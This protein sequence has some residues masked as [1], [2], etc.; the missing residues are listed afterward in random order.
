MKFRMCFL[1]AGFA[2]AAAAVEMPA[3]F[4]DNMVLQCDRAV[5]VWGTARPGENITVEFR[6]Q[7]VS[8]P[9]GEDGKWQV[10]LQPMTAD[11]AGATLTVKG[12]NT[13]TF[14]NV[15]TGDVW[16]CAG[17]SNMQFVLKDIDGGQELADKAENPN[18]RLFKFKR[19]WSRTPRTNVEGQWLMCEPESAR[20]FSAVGY[21]VGRDI[22]AEVKVPVGL[23]SIAWGGCRIE[24]MIDR[25]AWSEAQAPEEIQKAVA[26]AFGELDGR[27]DAKL[28]EDKQ[29]LPSVLFNA[30]VHPFSPFAVRGMLWYQGEDN[31]SEGMR[32]AEKLRVLAYCWRKNFAY[33]NMPIF[34]VQLPPFQYGNE[35][36][37]RIPNFW[38]AQQYFAE[39]DRN[40]GFVVA[41]DSGNPK[42]IHPTNKAPLAAR[43][44]KLVLYREYGI[45]DDSALAPTFR[46]CTRD[47][48][49][50]I[51]E[52]NHPN[53]LKTRD[54]QGVSHLML[55]GGGDEFHPASGVIENDKLIVT[56]PEVPAPARLRFGWDKVANPNLVNRAGVPAA[57]FDTGK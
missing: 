42:D 16:L 6:Q 22:A 33:E 52:F 55:S 15:L 1:I 26:G 14:Q 39:H 53:G 11:A 4:S 49:K 30:M 12:D 50:L 25:A 56:S 36:P 48:N 40:S 9:A 44:A 7:K 19:D 35:N 32:Y 57:P 43:L 51:V 41:T 20:A 47:G 24:S 5:P 17:Q 37:T 54:G 45:G 18:I 34:I 8:A 2:L 23:I 13:L 3:V 21:L 10:K 29:R 28:R 31:H 27:E 46:K 38:A